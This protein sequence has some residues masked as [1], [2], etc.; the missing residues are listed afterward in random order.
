MNG[1]DI[2]ADIVAGGVAVRLS[3]DMALALLREVRKPR[4]QQAAVNGS[5]KEFGALVD[6]MGKRLATMTLP[7]PATPVPHQLLQHGAGDWRCTCDAPMG[8]TRASA[9]QAIKTHVAALN[10]AAA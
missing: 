8:P 5:S 6:K 1:L 10:G 9:R 3:G 2:A 4:R 7:K